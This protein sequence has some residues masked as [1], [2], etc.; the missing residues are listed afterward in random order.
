MRGLANPMH[1]NKRMHSPAIR[2]PP[3][4]GLTLVPSSNRRATIGRTRAS[5]SYRTPEEVIAAVNISIPERAPPA[6]PKPQPVMHSSAFLQALMA[7]QQEQQ[8]LK[9]RDGESSSTVSAG[10]AEGGG[11]VSSWMTMHHP[12]LAIV[13]FSDRR[14]QRASFQS[15]PRLCN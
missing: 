7:S 13:R 8:Q 4:L 2:T 1:V 6:L 12:H 9:Q 14:K 3:A 11:T 5:T 15:M 10:R